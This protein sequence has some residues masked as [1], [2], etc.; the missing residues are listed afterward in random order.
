MNT[1]KYRLKLKYI[2]SE[3][4]L[5]YITSKQ[6]LKFKYITNEEISNCYADSLYKFKLKCKRTSTCK[7]ESTA[8]KFRYNS[9]ITLIKKNRK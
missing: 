2:I 8:S 1:S 6:R 3:Y 9:N 4:K 5:E 7:L